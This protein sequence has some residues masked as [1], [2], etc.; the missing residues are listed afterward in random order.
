[1]PTYE[2]LCKKC[3]HQFEYFQA[4]TDEP[5]SKCP[6]CKGK[7]TI[8][9]DATLEEVVEV[10]KRLMNLKMEF[11]TT[12]VVFNLEQGEALTIN[13]GILKIKEEK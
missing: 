2:Y 6:K 12:P 9:R 1:M 8:I 3:G 11:T 5:L 4:M 13:G 7:G 10:A